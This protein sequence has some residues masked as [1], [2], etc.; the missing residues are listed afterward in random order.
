M[1]IKNVESI[2]SP[3]FICNKIL[4]K[5]LINHNKIP[6]LSIKDN[7]YIFAETQHLKE[8]LNSLP[9]LMKIFT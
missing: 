1:F 3:I 2:Q 9:F 8:A 5:Y 4:G 7:K 6:I